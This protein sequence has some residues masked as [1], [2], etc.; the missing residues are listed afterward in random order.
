MPGFVYNGIRVE[1]PFEPYDI[2]KKYMRQVIDSIR[3]GENAMLESPTGTGKVK[4]AAC[5]D[6][7]LFRFFVQRYR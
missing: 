4:I 2:Q 3:N 6:R 1:F 7:R 5:C